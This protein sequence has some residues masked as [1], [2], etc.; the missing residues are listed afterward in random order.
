[1]TTTLESQTDQ[2]PADAEAAAG[3]LAERLFTAGLGALDVL[4][5]YVGVRLGLYGALA[6]RPGSTPGELAHDAG[7][8]PRYAREWLE[9]QTVTG[10][11]ECADRDAAAEQRRYA[12]PAGH[13]VVLLDADSPACMAPVA[14]A[15]GGIAGVLPQLLDAYRTGAGVPYAAYGTDFRDGQA[16]F[17]RPGFTALLASDWLA[18][19]LPDVHARMA[20]GEAL[21]VADVGCGAGWSSIALARAY[22]NVHVD[23]IDADDASIADARRNAAAAGVADRVTFEVRDAKDIAHDAYDL[24]CIFE[25]LHDMSR[26]VEVLTAIR[27]ARRADGTVLVMDERAAD[28][29]RES[30]GP[31]EA[32]LYACSVLHCL[33]VGMAEQPSAATGTVMRLDTVRS[34]AA[35]AGFGEVEVLPIEHDLFRF[36]RLG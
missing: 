7:I 26:P 25:A 31:I 20:Q 17:N 34:Y 23:G 3:A 14:L 4:T 21:R 35:D 9:Q 28:S 32:F 33:P 19:G 36:Y 29:F 5:V 30:D 10:I 24:V 22:P 11:V 13:A 1:V 27:A 6:A 12:L 16:G 15:A 8:A 2:S 18:T